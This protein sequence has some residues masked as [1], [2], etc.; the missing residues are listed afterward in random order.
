MQPCMDL[1]TLDATLVHVGALDPLQGVNGMALGFGRTSLA[2]SMIG[3][4]AETQAGIDDCAARNIK[5]DSAL[6]R[7][8]DSNRAYE[9]VVHKAVR[10]RFVIARA[11]MQSVAGSKS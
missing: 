3:G 2:G 10:Y 8:E 4:S 1:L 7:P 5:A 9:R 11:S 6:I